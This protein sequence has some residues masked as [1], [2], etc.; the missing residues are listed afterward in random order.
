[1]LKRFW[2]G[3]VETGTG[4]KLANK[5]EDDNDV[6]ND[7]FLFEIKFSFCLFN[8]QALVLVPVSLHSFINLDTA[9][10]FCRNGN[11]ISFCNSILWVLL[12]TYLVYP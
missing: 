5:E 4:I 2:K 7:I 8:S 3:G 1:M 12:I 11:P 6:A 9:S 10:T